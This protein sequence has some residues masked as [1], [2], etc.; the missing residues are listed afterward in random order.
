[1]KKVLIAAALMLGL[2]VSAQQEPGTPQQRYISRYASIAVN[3][4]YRTGVPASITLAQG[5]IESRSGQS[6]LAVDGNNHFG[7]KCHNSWRGKTML[8]D[9]DRKNEC[10]QLG[11][12]AGLTE[13]VRRQAP[14]RHRASPL[15]PAWSR[16]PS[17]DRQ[18]QS[19]LRFDR[20]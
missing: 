6:A 2:S 13:R 18:T 1:M 14:S 19:C 17:A 10:F 3:E 12:R 16:R 15:K 8:A 20:M 5:I 4:M 9:D 7:I 11:R